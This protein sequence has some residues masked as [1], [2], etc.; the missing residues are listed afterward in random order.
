MF[1]YFKAAISE[2][3]ELRMHE[4]QIRMESHARGLA[5]GK[6]SGLAEGRAAGLAEGE[7]RG[8]A[9]AYSDIAKKM[10]SLGFG[11]QDI[12]NLI[13]ELSPDEVEQLL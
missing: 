10:K 12:C 4:N 6:A 3:E 8:K 13:T 7:A 5:E 2:E 9:E 1:N 11:L